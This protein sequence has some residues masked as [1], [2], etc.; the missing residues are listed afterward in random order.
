MRKLFLGM[1]CIK[2]DA[3]T[4]DEKIVTREK[5]ECLEE[6]CKPQTEPNK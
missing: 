4:P 6:S 2:T 1:G 3:E 5:A